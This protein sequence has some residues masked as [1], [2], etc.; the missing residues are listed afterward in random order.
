MT[1]ELWKTFHENN[2]ANGTLLL[3]EELETLNRAGVIPYCVIIS[4][5]LQSAAPKSEAVRVVITPENKI[6]QQIYEALTSLKKSGIDFDQALVY[7]NDA[8]A[9]SQDIVQGLYN[10]SLEPEAFHVIEMEEAIHNKPFF[11]LMIT[12]KIFGTRLDE[13]NPFL[14]IIPIKALNFFVK[15]GK[16]PRFFPLSWLSACN[17]ENISIRVSF[18][19]KWSS[20]GLIHSFGPVRIL[21]YSL[22]LFF[23]YVLSSL[24]G[25][26]ADNSM[27]LLLTTLGI[28]HLLSLILSRIFSILINYSLL[29]TMV[30][31]EQGNRYE[32][33]LKYIG[34]VIFSSSIVWVGLD[35]GS[36]IFP[37]PAVII[38]MGIELM[39]FFF[40]YFISKTI[41]FRKKKAI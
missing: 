6:S 14:W 3:S 34:L 28:G 22:S 8:A 32:S 29:R 19:G 2:A 1:I 16:P 10:A 36:K 41:V 7:Q 24:T 26:I 23:R 11:I 21:F 33:F 40:N 15:S 12:K 39:M 20:Q 17:H 38:K 18:L 5:K 37:F 9:S 30:F 31:R 4:D 13:P 27:F 35:F 25:V